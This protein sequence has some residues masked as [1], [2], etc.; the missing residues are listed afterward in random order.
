MQRLT[1]DAVC[2]HV[3]AKGKKLYERVLK[4]DALAKENAEKT[5]RSLFPN[6][7]VVEL[8]DLDP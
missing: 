8:K 6:C 3:T 2:W 1:K 4:A 7:R 5:L